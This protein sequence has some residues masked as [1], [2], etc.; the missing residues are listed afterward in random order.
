MDEEE[1][2][3]EQIDDDAMPELIETDPLIKNKTSN[4][5]GLPEKFKKVWLNELIDVFICS[6]GFWCSTKTKNG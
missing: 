5:N 1:L 4:D 2:P 6:A 3:I